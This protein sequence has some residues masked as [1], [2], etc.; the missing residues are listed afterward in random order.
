MSISFEQAALDLLGSGPRIEGTVNEEMRR[1]ADITQVR[2]MRTWPVD[3]GQSKRGFVVLGTPNG[4][5]LINR[6]SHTFFVRHGLADSLIQT[7][8]TAL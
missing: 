6:V 8:L 5:D 1:L 2:V 3:T 7:A 4:A